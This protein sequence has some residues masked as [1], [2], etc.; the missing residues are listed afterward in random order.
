MFIQGCLGYSS[1]EP[2]LLG[3][4]MTSGRDPPKFLCH[5]IAV[6]GVHPVENTD[7]GLAVEQRAP[8][9]SPWGL[10]AHTGL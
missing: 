5:L 9:D 1:P 7:E 4:A 3:P 2:L 8:G 10:P 6:A